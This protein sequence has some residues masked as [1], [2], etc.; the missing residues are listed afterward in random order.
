MWRRSGL[1]A[2]ALAALA[3]ALA[4]CVE[5]L[6]IDGAEWTREYDGYFR[7][8]SKRF[9]GVAWDWRWWKSQAA[10]ESSLR[11]AAVSHAG[12][13]GI[14]QIMP[15]TWPDIAERSPLPFSDITDPGQNIGAGVFY[16]R[17]LWDQ[18]ADV[19]EAERLA[20]TL[21]SY[22]AG[23]GRTLRAQ[24]ACAC[25]TWPEVEPHLPSETV[26]YVARVMGLMGMER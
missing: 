17:W 9:F 12:A 1:I 2:A 10:A 6:P 4:G 21:G 7:R 5:R 16:D 3:V 25:S 11:P 20:F 24:S 8:Y 23:R 14:M 18:W 19:A 26:A 22:N 15:S 13:V